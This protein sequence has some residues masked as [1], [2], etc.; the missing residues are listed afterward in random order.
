MQ[1]FGPDPSNCP[2]AATFPVF[3][4]EFTWGQFIFDIEPLCIVD[5]YQVTIRDPNDL[6]TVYHYEYD[7]PVWSLA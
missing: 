3:Y 6:V 4:E 1:T 2:L 7:W 5:R